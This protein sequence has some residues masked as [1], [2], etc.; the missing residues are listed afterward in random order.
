MHVLLQDNLQE[1]QIQAAEDML[2]VF[3]NLI[4]ELYG[5]EHCTL[6]AHLLIQTSFNNKLRA[7]TSRCDGDIVLTGETRQG[8][9]SILRGHCSTCKH[10]PA[11][12]A[13][14]AM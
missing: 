14:N 10:T 13:G 8:L 2:I 11:L 5:N 4:P 1:A 6:N 3:Y 7:H 12:E 9:A